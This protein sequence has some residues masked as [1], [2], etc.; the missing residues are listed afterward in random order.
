MVNCAL[1]REFKDDQDRREWITIGCA[2]GFAAA[3][4]APVGGVL[5]ALEEMATHFEHRLLWRALCSTTGACVM[6]MWLQSN[7][8]LA[9]DTRDYG[10]ISFG[11]FKRDDDMALWQ[12]LVIGSLLGLMGGVLGVGFC[13]VVGKLI[14]ARERLFNTATRRVIE[15]L[16]LSVFCSAVSL[17]LVMH[18]GRCVQGSPPNTLEDWSLRQVC[19]KEHY[20][21][22]DAAYLLFNNREDALR[23]LLEAPGGF[24]ARTLLLTGL[25]FYFGMMLTYGS[26]ISMGVF[27]PSIMIGGT[28]GA[29]LGIAFNLAAGLD[30]NEL[31]GPWAML[32]AA[33]TLAGIQRTVISLCV[34]ILE[35]TGQIRFLLPCVICTSVAKWIGDHWT[36]PIYHITLHHKRVPILEQH[37]K[38]N[39]RSTAAHV[40]ASPVRWLPVQPRVSDVVGLLDSTEHHAFAVMD[41]SQGKPVIVGSVLRQQLRVMISQ[42]MFVHV[43]E[44]NSPRHASTKHHMRQSPQ[45]LEE[46]TATSMTQTKYSL[47]TEPGLSRNELGMRIDLEDVVNLAPVTVHANTPLKRA[48]TMFH[49][50]GLRHLYVHDNEFNIVG[51]ITREDLFRVQAGHGHQSLEEGS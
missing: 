17:V 36:L 18:L 16:A 14:P 34:I 2:T 19:P 48:H 28:L 30:Q 9:V 4:G 8:S 45:V 6:L 49:G 26:W 47:L 27:M 13:F 3:F 32:G 33:A 20:G 51:V 41:C 7:M 37:I 21:Y 22:N 39:H 42:R 12:A 10:V 24:S 40:M 1:L 5:F 15:V 23:Q 44:L 50:L 46:M 25:F 11:S 38:G 43:A 35:G 31:L 29:A